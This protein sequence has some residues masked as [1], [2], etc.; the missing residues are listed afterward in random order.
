MYIDSLALHLRLS[1]N[2]EARNLLKG[3]SFFVIFGE[4]WH[5]G[6]WLNIRFPIP[7]KKILLSYY[8]TGLFATGSIKKCIS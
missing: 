8:E 5:F 7:L 6:K 1:S 2:P 4:D 3:C